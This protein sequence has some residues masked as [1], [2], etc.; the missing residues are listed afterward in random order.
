MNTRNDI[1][2][3]TVNERLFTLGLMEDFDAAVA[4]RDREAMIATL[5][6]AELTRAQAEWTTDRLLLTPEFYGFFEDENG[7][8][9]QKPGP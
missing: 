7:L 8:L 6:R 1:A 2:G 5:Q 3:M 4:V 9:V